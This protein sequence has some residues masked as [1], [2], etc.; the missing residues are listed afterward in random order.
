MV[1]LPSVL[2]AV[3]ARVLGTR[4][5]ACCLLEAGG[6]RETRPSNQV[7]KVTVVCAV[8]ENSIPRLGCGET[9]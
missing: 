9:L 4:G 7:M 2:G 1:L 3:A 6:E 5:I 8:V